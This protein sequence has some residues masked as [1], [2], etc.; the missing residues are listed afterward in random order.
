ML[1][2]VCKCSSINGFR[3]PLLLFSASA[4]SSISTKQQQEEEEHPS[5]S[6]P[7]FLVENLGFSEEQ[8]LSISPKIAKRWLAEAGHSRDLGISG[9]D[10]VSVISANPKLIHRRLEPVLKDLKE[11]L[12]TPDNLVAFFKKPRFYLGNASSLANLVSNVRL[13]EKDYGISTDT[14]RGHIV[15]NQ[16]AFSRNSKLFTKILI[17]VEHK[18]GISPTSGMFLYG[19]SI[20]GRLSAKLIQSKI[21]LFKS[22]GWNQSH[23][24][25]I[26]KNN[27]MC[28]CISEARFTKSLEFLM[29]EMGY[30]PAFLACR[31]ALFTYSLETRLLPRQRILVVL[32]EK[33]LISTVC[34]LHNVAVLTES[35]FFNKFVKPFKDDIPDLYQ[36]YVSSRD[37]KTL[38]GEKKV[39]IR[40]TEMN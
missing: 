34:A 12:G 28:L 19:V 3:P 1:K 35:K 29:N 13:L 25:T 4:Y 8:S 23:I 16:V 15:H 22:F 24:M 39:T 5:A 26:I 30:E 18:W 32:K 11:L 20:F 27:P 21:R 38:S 9:S 14:V 37:C 33:G 36:N 7:N 17:D 10:L 40:P 2:L 31:L 6:L